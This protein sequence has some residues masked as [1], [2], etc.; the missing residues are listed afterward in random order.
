LRCYPGTAKGCSPR[1]GQLRDG[2]DPPYSLS[3]IFAFDAFHLVEDL[4]TQ[5]I[6]MVA[7][8][9]AGSCGTPPDCMRGYAAKT[10]W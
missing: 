4:F 8:S 2:V 6:L 10:S 5:P 7:G 9:D 3:K 1:F